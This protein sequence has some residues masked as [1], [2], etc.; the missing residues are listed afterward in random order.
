MFVDPLL[1]GLFVFQR[2]GRDRVLWT[3]AQDSP[4]SLGGDTATRSDGRFS[5]TLG[6]FKGVPKGWPFVVSTWIS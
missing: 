3:V 5:S 2:L 4:C 1:V 6:Y